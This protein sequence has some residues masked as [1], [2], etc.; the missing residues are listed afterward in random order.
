VAD[1]LEILAL[2][3]E[4]IQRGTR[5]RRLDIDQLNLCIDIL[6]ASFIALVSVKTFD[7][8]IRASS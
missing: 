3:Q 1:L 4:L 8:E 5:V 7:L 6:D 2:R